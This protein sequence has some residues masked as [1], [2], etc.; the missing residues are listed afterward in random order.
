MT[1]VR[2]WV[3]LATMALASTARADGALATF[4]A[5]LRR[6]AAGEG[7]VRV[8][9][10]GDSHVC[11]D[12]LTGALRRILQTRFGDA[13]PGLVP[14]IQPTPYCGH[15]GL[16]ASHGGA[17][18]TV[19]TPPPRSK[20]PRVLADCGLAGFAAESRS[21][22][23]FTQLS[24]HDVD[25]IDLSLLGQPGGG[26]AIVRIDDVPVLA[27]PTAAAAI[28][29]L[30]A[31]VAPIATGRHRL[32][33]RPAG[34]GPVRLLSLA[35]DT[36]APGAVVDAL[37]IDGA[38]IDSQLLC[39]DA[40]VAAE[41][42]HRPPDLAV[43]AYGTNE[44]IS[45]RPTPAELETALEHVL[46]RLRAATPSTSCMVVGPADT[47]AAPAARITAVAEV[48][49]R[50]ALRHGCA[51]FDTVLGQGGPGATARWLALTPPFVGP[52]LVHF[53]RE[54]YQALAESL[55]AALTRG[56]RVAR[57]E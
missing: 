27:V 7:Q 40:V 21:T 17:W 12:G 5:G 55:T 29:T 51:F 26:T 23:A 22:D 41:L 56:W 15:H 28:R 44:V 39:R 53:T 30:S 4:K 52:D 32:E 9:V 42:E 36:G 43:L 8:L 19:G 16:R 50:V 57:A 10:Q 45:G 38:R 13:G 46:T 31:R 20:A 1:A 14:P 35:L 34:D 49:R 11:S 47:P 54:G 3:L 2:A 25:R 37:G 48:Q 33:V 24:F 6:A 18:T